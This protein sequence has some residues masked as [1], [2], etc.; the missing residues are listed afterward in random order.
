MLPL[1]SVKKYAF[2]VELLVV[3]KLLKL[4]IVELPAIVT[5]GNGFR[6][7]HMLRMLV[8]LL[9]ISYRL[10]MKRW[11]QI[12]IAKRKVDPYRPIMKW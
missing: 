8:D 11:Y 2:D 10:R 5:L 4:K 1:I 12:N 3:A 6:K 7:R 9:G